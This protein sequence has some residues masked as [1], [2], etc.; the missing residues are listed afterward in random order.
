[1][2]LID[3]PGGRAFRRLAAALLAAVGAVASACPLCLGWGQP[4]LVQQMVQAQQV[5]L[6]RPAAA[7]GHYEVIAPIKGARL[8]GG[9]VEAAPARAGPVTTEGPGRKPWVLMRSGE[10]PVW[11]LVGS[12][13]AE[14]AGTLRQL[15]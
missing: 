3:V 7:A 4:S 1:M 15:A 8:P 9:L 10:S 2:S 13:G 14:H 11:T 12:L 5:V 6:A